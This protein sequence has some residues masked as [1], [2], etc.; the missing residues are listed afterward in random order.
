MNMR[1]CVWQD[2]ME[3]EVY[4]TWLHV[5][6]EKGVIEYVQM[7]IQLPEPDII[8][9]TKSETEEGAAGVVWIQHNKEMKEFWESE[10]Q[11]G[12]YLIY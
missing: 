10:I 3:F 11:V 9:N 2:W 1:E 5:R 6:E 12:V 7:T 4:E 8:I